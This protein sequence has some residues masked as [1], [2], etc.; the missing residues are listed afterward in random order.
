M[1]GFQILSDTKTLNQKILYLL[2]INFSMVAAV[3][4][5]MANVSDI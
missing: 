3:S 5:F 2:F 4:T 1:Q